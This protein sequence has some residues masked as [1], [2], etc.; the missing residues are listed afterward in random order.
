MGAF[1]Q[2]REARAGGGTVDRIAWKEKGE[3]KGA[4]E[5]IF[6]R[7]EKEGFPNGFVYLMH[8]PLIESCPV[9]P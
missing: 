5:S 1:W 6:D 3:E 4:E 9:I 7:A 8:M 2:R